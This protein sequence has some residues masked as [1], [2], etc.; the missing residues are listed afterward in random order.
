MVRITCEAALD[1][2]R[3]K[4][5]KEAQRKSLNYVSQLFGVSRGFTRYWKRKYIDRSY[6]PKPNGGPKTF[7]FDFYTR[8]LIEELIWILVCEDPTNVLNYYVVKARKILNVDINNQYVSRIFKRWGWSWKII[9]IRKIEK[10]TP[11]NIFKYYIHALCMSSLPL[12]KLKFLDESGF[13]L[14]DIRRKYGIGPIGQ[15]VYRRMPSKLNDR[16]NLILLSSLTNEVPYY[17]EIT[18]EKVDQFFIYKFIFNSIQE[19][20]LILVI[21]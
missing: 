15:R 2:I 7:K 17:I 16:Y 3:K 1:N 19:V 9:D 13:Q 11:K 4:V 6:H 10:Y 8:N 20:I 21:F 14:K 5:G 12:S 18:T